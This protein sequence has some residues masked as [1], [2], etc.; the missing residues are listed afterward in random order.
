MVQLRNFSGWKRFLIIFVDYFLL[1]KLLTFTV[2]YN[3]D[4]E[5][6]GG[7]ASFGYNLLVGLNLQSY[8]GWNEEDAQ[9]L[10]DALE[11][12]GSGA[13]AQLIANTYAVVA[14]EFI[15][16]VMKTVE[17]SVFQEAQLPDSVW[18]QQPLPLCSI[19]RPSQDQTASTNQS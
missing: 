11:E 19:G 2:A 3:T 18:L 9:Y 10:Y 13:E 16:K 6:A 17:P 7:S 5:L 15:A 12:T 1:N 14:P 4:R 8:G